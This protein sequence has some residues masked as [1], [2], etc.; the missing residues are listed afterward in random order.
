MGQDFPSCPMACPTVGRGYNEGMHQRLTLCAVLLAL[1]TTLVAAQGASRA[2]A[3]RMSKKVDAILQRFAAPPKSAK[4]LTTNFSERELNAYL[5]LE[6]EAA[7]LPPGLTQP[8]VTLLD[9]GKL[10]T[11][12]LVNLDAVRTAQKRGWLDPLAYITGILEVR[13]LGTLRGANGKGVYT[14]ESASLDG[15]PIPKTVLQELLAFYTRT[16]ETPAGIV[17]DQPFDLPVGIRQ[18]D[19]RRGVATVVQ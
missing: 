17:L 14:F 3:D 5:H 13:T 19:L 9:D 18:V 12:A 4:P 15:V 8:R 1:T 6:G 10:D 7:G 11:R 2:D 16:P